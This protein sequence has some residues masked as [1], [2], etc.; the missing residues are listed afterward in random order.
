MNKKPKGALENALVITREDGKGH[1]AL[2]IKKW[3]VNKPK[4]VIELRVE[5][6]LHIR[7][8]SNFPIQQIL[9]SRGIWINMM[10]Y[11]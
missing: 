3:V 8:N 5:S 2:V 4:R 7:S 1:Q 9:R 10:Q 6:A 11:A